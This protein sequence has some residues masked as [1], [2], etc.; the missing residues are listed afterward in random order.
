MVLP[1][2]EKLPKNQTKLG[3]EFFTAAELYRRG[4]K[5]GITLGNTE[6]IDLLAEKGGQ[7]FR[8][9]VKGVQAKASICW[10]ISR[11]RVKSDIFFVLVN[12]NADT[13]KAPNF[14]VLTS[15]EM[16]Q[17]LKL[18]ESRRDYLDIN[19]VHTPDFLDRWDKF[20]IPESTPLIDL[21]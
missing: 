15:G 17:K 3:A 18:V 7:S 20:E 2:K 21:E 19:A 1:E 9:Q 10:N 8:I 14:Y 11:E 5:V 16:Q 13:L 12:L 4:F 6:D